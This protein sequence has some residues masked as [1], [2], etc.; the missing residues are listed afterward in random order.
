MCVLLAPQIV[1]HSTLSLSYTRH[2]AFHLHNRLPCAQGFDEYM[3]IVLEDA[4]EISLKRKTRKSLGA[5]LLLSSHGCYSLS[6]NLLAFSSS[7]L[8][9]HFPFQFV[10]RSPP[11]HSLVGARTPPRPHN[12]QGRQYHSDV[13]RQGSIISAPPALPIHVQ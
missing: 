13:R 12:A 9:S 11:R 7:L 10:Y 8:S 2:I 3:N 5:L 6:S 1:F 4:E